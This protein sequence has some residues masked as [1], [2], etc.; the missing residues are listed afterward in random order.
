MAFGKCSSIPASAKLFAGGCAAALMQEGFL[1]TFGEGCLISTYALNNCI[2]CYNWRAGESSVRC[3]GSEVR[4][5]IVWM[6][7]RC[8]NNLE[9][10]LLHGTGEW[11]TDK[12]AALK[13]YLAG[14]P[15]YFK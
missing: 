13:G 3:Y 14:S 6:Q 15:A 8:W 11:S 4:Y 12:T 10:I 7:F 2:W 5:S 9:L 1:P